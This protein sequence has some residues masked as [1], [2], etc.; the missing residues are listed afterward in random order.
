MVKWII[1][2]YSNY[3]LPKNFEYINPTYVHIMID[4]KIVLTGGRELIE[5]IDANGWMV[6]EELGIDFIETEQVEQ[7]IVIKSCY[8]WSLPLVW[9]MKIKT[10]H[11]K[12]ISTD[13]IKITLKDDNNES[14]WKSLL[15]IQVRLQ[16]Y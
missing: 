10:S 5:K 9:P 11:S 4:G 8:Q 16:L 3:T 2:L 15:V 12:T 6:K 14:L 1:R 13:P 7:Q